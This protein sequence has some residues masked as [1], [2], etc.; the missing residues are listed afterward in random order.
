MNKFDENRQRLDAIVREINS[1]G[2]TE[3]LQ[4]QL[5]DLYKDCSILILLGPNKSIQRTDKSS[6]REFPDVGDFE[7]YS[8][9][10]KDIDFRPFFLI[11]RLGPVSLQYEQNQV[12]GREFPCLRVTWQDK[13]ELLNWSGTA[14]FKQTFE[15]LLEFFN[16]TLGASWY[17]WQLQAFKA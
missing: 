4:A 3:E 6:A 17:R 7:Y 1:G 2:M 8:G 10:F 13:V 5:L 12:D 9:T 16:V 14:D 15:A 11:E